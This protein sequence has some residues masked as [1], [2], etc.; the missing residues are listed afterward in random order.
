MTPLLLPS[1]CRRGGCRTDRRTCT[2]RGSRPS[3]WKRE[4]FSCP[5]GLARN[6]HPCQLSRTCN[7]AVSRVRCQTRRVDFKARL[8]NSRNHATGATKS[9]GMYYRSVSCESCPKACLLTW[10]TC[11]GWSVGAL[12]ECSW[13]RGA[14]AIHRRN[15]NE[16]ARDLARFRS[17]PRRKSCC[18]VVV[19]L[20]WCNRPFASDAVVAPSRGGLAMDAPR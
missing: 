18:D 13:G 6:S 3:R 7:L 12:K 11:A 5:P 10:K 9:G 15:A 4:L 17:V 16:S 14:S 8:L 2:T 20:S 19:A 1:L